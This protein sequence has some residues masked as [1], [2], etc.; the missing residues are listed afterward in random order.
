V[1]PVG[2]GQTEISVSV[3]DK[4][5]LMLTGG[6][7]T[8]FAQ[9]G[10]VRSSLRALCPSGFSAITAFSPQ[11]TRSNAERRTENKLDSEFLC[12]AKFT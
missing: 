5:R 8:G 1:V 9:K 4:E 3:E 12:K 6:K 10:V 7:F 11:R 2:P